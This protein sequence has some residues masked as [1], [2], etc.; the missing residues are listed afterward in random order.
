MSG[1]IFFSWVITDGVASE[2]VK[3]TAQEECDFLY[4]FLTSLKFTDRSIS[5]AVY[6]R[7]EFFIL[8]G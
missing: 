7:Q 5:V 6:E 8:S 3:I 1:I 2:G 4:C